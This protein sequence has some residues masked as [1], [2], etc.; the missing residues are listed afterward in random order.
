MRRFSTIASCCALFGCFVGVIAAGQGTDEV[1]DLGD[2]RYSVLDETHF[3]AIHGSGWVLMDG[4]SINGTV[5][6]EAQGLCVLPDSRGVFIRGMN[7]SRSGSTGDPDGDRPLGVYQRDTLAS[8]RHRVAG[9][10]W[11]DQNTDGLSSKDANVIAG[12]WNFPEFRYFDNKGLI[13]N[14]GGNETRPRNIALYT[15]IRVAK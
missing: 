13:E 14:T 8:H 11:S 12:R 2:V 6:C 1:P 15:Y 4:R 7:L 9:S 3:R 10:D 5:L